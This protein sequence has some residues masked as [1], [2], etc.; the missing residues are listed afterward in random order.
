MD[1]SDAILSGY[2]PLAF[3][4]TIE[5]KLISGT[6]IMLCKCFSKSELKTDQFNRRF[7]YHKCWDVTA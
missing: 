4:F 1:I 3:T 5:V 7:S 2:M 6:F